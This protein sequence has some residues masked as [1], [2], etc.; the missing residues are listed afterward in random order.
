MRALVGRQP[1]AQPDQARRGGVEGANVGR[2]FA[3]LCNAQAGD[4]RQLVDING[5]TTWI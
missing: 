1:V 4:D 3:I 2:D 5:A